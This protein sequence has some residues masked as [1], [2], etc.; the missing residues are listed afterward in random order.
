MS[1]EADD[2][3]VGAGV[4]AKP[5]SNGLTAKT[6]PVT[7]LPAKTLTVTTVYTLTSWWFGDVRRWLPFG[8]KAAEVIARGPCRW[9]W[10]VNHPIAQMTKYGYESSREAALSAADAVLLQMCDGADTAPAHT[11]PAHAAPASSLQAAVARAERAEAI[12]AAWL[13]LRQAEKELREALAA[14]RALGVEP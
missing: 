6:S 9:S 1:A 14:L 11:V 10:T 13:R 8:A 3:V 4:G 7:A 12:A 2:A 5:K